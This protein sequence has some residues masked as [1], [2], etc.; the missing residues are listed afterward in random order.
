MKGLTFRSEVSMDL[1]ST[2]DRLFKDAYFYSEYDKADKN[3]ISRSMNRAQTMRYENTLTY[4]NELAS[5]ASRRSVGQTTEE[6][7]TT[8]SAV[9]APRSSTPRPTTGI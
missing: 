1:A 8:S 5:T 7:N 2:R 9:P 6:Y 4:R 3:Y